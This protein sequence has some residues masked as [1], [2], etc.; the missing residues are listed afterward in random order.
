MLALLS[1]PG[2]QGTFNNVEINGY[3]RSLSDSTCIPGAFILIQR[4]HDSRS[5]YVYRTDANGYFRHYRTIPTG[6]WEPLKYSIT[7]SDMDGDTN[8]IF[9]SSDTVVYDDNTAHVSDIVF[10]VEIYVQMVEDTATIPFEISI[11][12]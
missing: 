5:P 4:V 2:D 7:A 10:Q 12:R 1:C 9:I 6:N 3:V 11:E 8:G